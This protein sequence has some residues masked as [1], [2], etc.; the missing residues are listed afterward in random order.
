MSKP[1]VDRV[2]SIL[3]ML[4]SSLKQAG[5]FSVKQAP[6]VIQQLLKW[7]VVQSIIG[8]VFSPLI[9]IPTCIIWNIHR[10]YMQQCG[11]YDYCG[12]AFA[13][14]H[15]LYIPLVIG[16]GLWFIQ[17][18]SELIKVTIAPKLFLLEHIASQAKK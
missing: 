18:L 16:T 3:S 4:E 2:D 7:T 14:T 5:T 13:I 15:L 9:L 17:S 1:I 11:A 6:D 10:V 8:I 12:E